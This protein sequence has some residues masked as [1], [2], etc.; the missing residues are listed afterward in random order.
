VAALPSED[1]AFGVVLASLSLTYVLDRAAAARE[2]HEYC[3][4]RG[5]WWRLCGWG[6]RRVILCCFNT[7]LAASRVPHRPRTSAWGL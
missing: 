4:R 7:R 2:L 6:Q 5:G 3:D 1:D